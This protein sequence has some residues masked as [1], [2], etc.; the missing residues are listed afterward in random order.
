MKSTLLSLILAGAAVLG[1]TQASAVTY[2]NISGVVHENLV[3]SSAPAAAPGQVLGDFGTNPSAHVLEIVGNT[4]IYGGLV[5]ANTARNQY[6]DGWT[7]DFGTGIYDVT[8]NWAGD[9]RSRFN[10][11][12]GEFSVNGASTAI[13]E[14]GSLTYRGLTGQVTFLIDPVAG[15]STPREQA[16]WDLQVVA[17]VPLPASAL[18]LAVGLAGLGALRRRTV[19]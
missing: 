9:Q 1:A 6:L 15:Q 17:A 8:F 7:L 18:L 2:Q 5:H 19:A 3:P 13:G 10:A 14:S 16:T 4:S 12:D 11:F